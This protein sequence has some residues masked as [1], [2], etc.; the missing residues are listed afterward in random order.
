[1]EYMILGE[2]FAAVTGGE[3]SPGKQKMP[4]PGL[5]A[6]SD[7]VDKACEGL[8]DR[9]IKYSIR[10]IREMEERLCKLERELDDF[11]ISKTG[12]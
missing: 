10:R 11:L 6:F 1:M 8:M 9:H 7:V 2:K 3:L 12:K 5:Y 4:E